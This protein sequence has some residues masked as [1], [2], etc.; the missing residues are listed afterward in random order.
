[1]NDNR[2]VWQ[3]IAKLSLSN[4]VGSDVS[5]K[6]SRSAILNS[7]G[8]E[9]VTN[10]SAWSIKINKSGCKSLELYVSSVVQS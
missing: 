10:L 3:K 6:R 2:K 5:S 1:V 9:A 7:Q 4:V 8:F